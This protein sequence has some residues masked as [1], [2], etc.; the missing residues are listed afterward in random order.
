MANIEK[1]IPVKNA[2]SEVMT[3]ET[4][5][6]INRTIKKFGGHIKLHK[7]LEDNSNEDEDWTKSKEGEMLLQEDSEN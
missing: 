7:D 4:L 6:N 1:C 5:K 2:A 3:L